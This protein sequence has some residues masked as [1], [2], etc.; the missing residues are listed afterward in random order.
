MEVLPARAQDRAMQ[1][2]LGGCA[3]STILGLMAVS[4]FG[5]AQQPVNGPR[6]TVRV[7]DFVNLSPASRNELAATANRVL[8]QAGVVI[9][10]VACYS[11]GMDSGHPACT[12][13]PGP[14]DLILRI[15][16]PRQTVKSE[17][18]GYAAMTPEGGAYISVFLKAKALRARGS[19]LSE[20]TLLGYA[21]AHE[22][23][24]L[25]LGA[26]SHSPAGVMRS[27]WDP[28]D[29][30]RMARGLLLFNPGEA[31]RMRGTLI[32]RVGR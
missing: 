9:G 6:L 8:S 19:Y 17:Q 26:D 22:V 15:L 3:T 23:G 27:L 30:E 5:S 29:K 7:Y 16:P 31:S 18:L 4:A 1:S 2:N 10:F 13:P 24:H 12:G 20:G 14:A 25:L 11:G 28:R 32:A 21:V